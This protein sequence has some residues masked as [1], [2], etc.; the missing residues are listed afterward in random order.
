MFLCW[1]LLN[2]D[3]R[4]MFYKAEQNLSTKHFV[5]ILGQSQPLAPKKH[6]KSKGYSWSVPTLFVLHSTENRYQIP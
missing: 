5:G 3:I 6:K 4:E 2:F 1:F